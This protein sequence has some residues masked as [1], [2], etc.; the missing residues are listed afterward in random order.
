MYFALCLKSD[1]Q[2]RHREPAVARDRER[3]KAFHQIARNPSAPRKFRCRTNPSL[4][5]A[6]PSS[7]G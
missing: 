7:P 1:L 6:A 2:L 5:S 3:Y 4:R